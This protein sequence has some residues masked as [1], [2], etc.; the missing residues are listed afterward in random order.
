MPESKVNP[1]WQKSWDADK[2][3]KVGDKVRL[4]WT[5]SSS[6]YTGEAEVVK[7]NDKSIRAKLLT[8]IKTSYGVA[9][10]VGHEITVS[11]I[12]NYQKWTYSH[13][14]VLA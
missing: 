1:E 9:Y 7:V 14:F 4:Y 8:E 11:R 3:V 13:R 2:V 12:R 5:S 6:Q 10:K